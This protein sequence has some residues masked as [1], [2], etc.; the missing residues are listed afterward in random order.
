MWC[1]AY[2]FFYDELFN[3]RE[4]FIDNF[5]KRKVLSINCSND[6]DRDNKYKYLYE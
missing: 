4:L 3:I 6:D 1:V 5:A 2:G